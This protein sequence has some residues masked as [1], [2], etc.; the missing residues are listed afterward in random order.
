MT[1]TVTL[2]V[3]YD[4]CDPYGHVNHANYFRYMGYAAFAVA[5]H[6]ETDNA[7][8]H[9]SEYVWITRETEVEFLNPLTFGDTAHVK[10]WVSDFRKVR[11]L[12]L[13]EIHAGDSSKPAARGWTD[14]VYARRDT[15][16]PAIVPNEVVAQ[17]L[18]KNSGEKRVERTRFPKPAPYAADTGDMPLKPEWRDLDP[19][20][21]INN[22]GWLSYVENG[23]WDYCESLGWS[24]DRMQ[25]EGFGVF[26]RK[27]RIEYLKPAGINDRF[28]LK[29]WIAEKRR[30]TAVRHYEIRNSVDDSLLI[31]ARCL[32]VWVDLAK[33][34][35]IKIPAGFL[36]DF[37]QN[38]SPAG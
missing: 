31:R 2:P 16:L 22:A 15:G 18:A 8:S 5:D 21:H 4:E 23:T 3:R 38:F 13:Y 25:A 11:S 30:A 28:Y 29:T 17:F 37:E 7:H 12:R 14:W 34:S 35:P 10:T 27:Y 26:A 24:A 36:A 20:G 1:F 32:W 9:K 33:G 6:L 19:N